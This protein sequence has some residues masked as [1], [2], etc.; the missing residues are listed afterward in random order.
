MAEVT[1]SLIEYQELQS[2]R[3]EARDRCAQLE[4]RIHEVEMTDPSDR[5]PPL[6]ECVQAA[7]PIVKFAVGNMA[8]ETVRGWPYAELQAFAERLET[9]PGAD[10]RIREYALEFRNFILEAKTV[11]AER[12]R[13]DEAR[14][15]AAAEPTPAEPSVEP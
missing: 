9:M 10:T 1:M 12:V 15:Q 4:K 8:P 13:M 5:I 7:L 11:E 2:Q 3:D 14:A 6:V